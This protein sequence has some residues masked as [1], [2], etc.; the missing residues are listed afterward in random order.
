MTGVRTFLSDD[1][2][3][4]ARTKATVHLTTTRDHHEHG[5]D[6]ANE[7]RFL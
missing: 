6:H 7:A 3:R 2:C 4:S 1:R 5:P